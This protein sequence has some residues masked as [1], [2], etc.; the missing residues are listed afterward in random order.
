MLDLLITA[1]QSRKFLTG[2]IW[3]RPPSWLLL[4]LPAWVHAAPKRVWMDLLTLRGNKQNTF[5]AIPLDSLC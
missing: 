5:N 1:N 2:Y 4:R 3:E